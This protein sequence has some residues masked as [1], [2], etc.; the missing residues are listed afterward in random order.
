[1]SIL[2]T[3]SHSQL[4]DEDLQQLTQELCQ[5]IDDET[6]MKPQLVTTE[7]KQGTKAADMITLGAIGL[8][9]FSS[10]AAVALCE[11]LKAYFSREPS[12]E[13]V[14]KDETGL[15]VKVNAKNV[16]LTEIQQLLEQLCREQE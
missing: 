9:F 6:E 5:I 11:V 13:L 1:M 15:E 10:G 3:V 16:E 7:G 12:L 2:L 8:A 14:F 4:D